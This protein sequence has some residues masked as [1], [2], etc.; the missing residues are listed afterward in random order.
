MILYDCLY[1][2]IK[3]GWYK[4]MRVFAEAF[5]AYGGDMILLPP[6]FRTTYTGADNQS[7]GYDPVSD[8]DIGQ[9]DTLRGGSANDLQALAKEALRYGLRLIFDLPLH[10]YGALP[11]VERNASGKPDKTLAYKPSSVFQAAPDQTFE[12]AD[13]DG[14]RVPYQHSQPSDYLRKLKIQCV[15]WLMSVSAGW[16]FRLDEAKDVDMN[17]THRLAAAIPGFK[18]A[19]AYTGSNA[20]LDAYHQQSALPVF[21]FGSHFAYRAVSQGAGLDALVYMDRYC[22]ANPSAAV[23]FIE[24]HDTDGAEGVVNFKGWFYLDACT[25]AAVA[26]AIYGGDYERYGLAPLINN[27]M[28]IGKRLAAGKQS[29]H[30]VS[31]D[32]LIWS[33]DG[34]GGPLGNTAGVLCGISRDPFNT[35]WIWTDT[36][37]RNCWIKN[38][39]R[40]GGPNVWVYDDGRAC[41]PI[42]PNS[43]GRADNGVA[44]SL[45]G[46]D[47]SLSTNELHIPLAY[48]LDFSHITVTL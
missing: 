31:P 2:A 35:Q 12:R 29:Y 39:A 13:A 19:E 20:Q 7:L 28:W 43:Y 17:L 26:C 44:Y 45:L 4:R 21:D 48:P 15:A 24:N 32:V 9:W 34:N 47:R 46:Q 22:H 41:V 5:A 36:P 1:P 40:S 30:V 14:L 11:V 10:Q 3:S 42:P 16:G 25:Q 33:R 6:P 27:Y 18:V 37:W 38:Y 8:L 23:P